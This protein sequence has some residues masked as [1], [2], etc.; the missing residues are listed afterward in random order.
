[1]RFANWSWMRKKN[2]CGKVS[3]VDSSVQ[4][5]C[6]DRQLGHQ[7]EIIVGGSFKTKKLENLKA[8][9]KQVF[10]PSVYTL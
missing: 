2:I 4:F 5:I 3:S 7:R 8:F 10:D 1:M 9:P 6:M